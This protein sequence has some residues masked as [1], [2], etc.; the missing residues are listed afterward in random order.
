MGCRLS[1]GWASLRPGPRMRAAIWSGGQVFDVSGD[2][3]LV[4]VGIG[5]AGEAVAG[6]LIG[7]L[8]HRLGVDGVAGG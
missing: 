1:F 8:G 6:D 4:A 2:G 5:D 3:S 7:G